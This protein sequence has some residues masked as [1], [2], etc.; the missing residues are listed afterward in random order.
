MNDSRSGGTWNRSPSTP[1]SSTPASEP[2]PRHRH[3]RPRPPSH[4]QPQPAHP[5]LPATLT[6]GKPLNEM[7]TLTVDLVVMFGRRRATSELNRGDHPHQILRPRTKRQH[8]LR[9]VDRAQ[10]LALQDV[11]QVLPNGVGRAIRL[12]GEAV[13]RVSVLRFM[14]RCR[15]SEQRLLMPRH[16]LLLFALTFHGCRSSLFRSGAAVILF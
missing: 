14:R 6:I 11:D 8:L 9:A 16:S 13:G 15:S 1:E 7:T 12:V 3:P 5:D 2:Y 10:Q 4:Q